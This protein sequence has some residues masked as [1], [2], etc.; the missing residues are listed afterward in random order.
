MEDQN[1]ERIGNIEE[2]ERI[3]RFD[4]DMEDSEDG[5]VEIYSEIKKY[6]EIEEYSIIELVE[7][8][9]ICGD[10]FHLGKFFFT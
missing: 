7:R 8:C 10:C 4:D 2:Q 9:D 6:V 5:H 3:E 1:Y